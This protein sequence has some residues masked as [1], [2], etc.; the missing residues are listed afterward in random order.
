[1]MMK[2]KPQKT[3]AMLHEIYDAWRAHNLDWLGTYLPE[4]FSHDINIPPELYPLGGER[5]GKQAALDRLRQ[6]FEQFDTQ[7]LSTGRFEIDDEKAT[8][9]VSTLCVHRETGA[10]FDN[11]KRNL[12]RMESGWPTRLEEHYDLE[13]VESF[14]RSLP[15]E[16]VR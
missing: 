16:K 4:D 1:M 9:E 12:W 15:S 2:K 5:L 7:R 8:L 13:H 6:L 3:G 14:L 11:K 10:H